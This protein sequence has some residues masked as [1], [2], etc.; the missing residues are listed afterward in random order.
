MKR[1]LYLAVGVSDNG[2]GIHSED[3]EKIFQS[4]FPIK[5]ASRGTGL[6]LYMGGNPG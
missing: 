3:K 6:G 5:A 2:W 4:L 1:D